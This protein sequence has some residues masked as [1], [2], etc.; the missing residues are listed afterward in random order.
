MQG[1]TTL[2]SNIVLDPNRHSQNLPV[3]PSSLSAS[4][5]MTSLRLRIRQLMSYKR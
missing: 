5:A 3:Q 2:S 1:N 4:Q